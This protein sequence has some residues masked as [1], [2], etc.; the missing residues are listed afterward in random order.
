MFLP[1]GR[2]SFLHLHFLI[3][4]MGSP[5]YCAC[6]EHFYESS[7]ASAMFGVEPNSTDDLSMLVRIHATL[8]PRRCRCPDHALYRWKSSP[9]KGSLCSQCPPFY[10]TRGHGLFMT[11]TSMVQA[12]ST[13]AIPSSVRLHVAFLQDTSRRCGAGRFFSDIYEALWPNSSSV[14]EGTWECLAGLLEGGY[15]PQN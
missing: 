12:E 2:F 13:H 9:Q 11:E 15:S 1:G 8:C 5:S 6:I 10:L 14:R 3:S 4:T 7:T